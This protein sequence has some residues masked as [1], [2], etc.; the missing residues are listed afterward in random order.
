[1]VAYLN[2]RDILHLW[3]SGDLIIHHNQVK[4]GYIFIFATMI[5][6]RSTNLNDSPFLTRKWV[7]PRMGNFGLKYTSNNLS[8]PEKTVPAHPVPYSEFYQELSNTSQELSQTPLNP[9]P[10]VV[11]H[12][13]WPLKY[14]LKGRTFP[15]QFSHSGWTVEWIRQGTRSRY[16]DWP[17]DMQKVKHKLLIFHLFIIV[18]FIISPSSSW[19]G[20]KHHNFFV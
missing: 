2:S 12:L 13:L 1:M 15:F 7:G 19:Q 4:Y 18:V 17:W 14:C 5:M 9:R 6:C 10:N 3:I 16:K 8:T 20:K 11:L